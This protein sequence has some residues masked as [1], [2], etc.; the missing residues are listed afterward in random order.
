MERRFPGYFQRNILNWKGK[1]CRV[2]PVAFIW[3]SVIGV[4]L[5]YGFQPNSMMRYVP[6]F[7]PKDKPVQDSK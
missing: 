2:A 1:I 5:F 3:G 4:T 6:I 7:G